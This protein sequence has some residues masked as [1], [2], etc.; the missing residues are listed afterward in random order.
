MPTCSCKCRP[1]FPHWVPRGLGFELESPPARVSGLSFHLDGG[2]FLT[3]AIMLTSA[4]EFDG[5]AF[6]IRSRADTYDSCSENITADKG[7]IV[8]WRGFYWHGVASV[9]RGRRRVLVSEWWS[10]DVYKDNLMPARPPDTVEGV[11]AALE[12]TEGVATLHVQAAELLKER[13]ALTSNHLKSGAGADQRPQLQLKL[14]FRRAHKP[15]RH[16]IFN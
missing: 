5:G 4:S 13:E 3:V 9:T 16:A 8:A 12:E 11:L 1:A 6:R 14:N 7:D 10:P 2:T 15:K